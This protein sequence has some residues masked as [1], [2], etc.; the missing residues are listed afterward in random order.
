MWLDALDRQRLVELAY[1][2]GK[3]LN[4]VNK[5]YLRWKKNT[6]T[7]LELGT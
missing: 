6:V 7:M 4:L 1:Q 3:E 5:T 2:K